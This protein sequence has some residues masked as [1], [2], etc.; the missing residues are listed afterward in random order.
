MFA[1]KRILICLG[2]GVPVPVEN[3]HLEGALKLGKRNN[4]VSQVIIGGKLA[5]EN[6]IFDAKFGRERGFGRLLRRT[7]K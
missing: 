4:V 7:N 2:L 6:G 5:F 3:E 1:G